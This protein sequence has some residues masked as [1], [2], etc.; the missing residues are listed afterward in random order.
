[1]NRHAH[2]P[3]RLTGVAAVLAALLLG[4]GGSPGENTVTL[5][6][7][8][9]DHGDGAANSS[10]PRFDEM[11]TLPPVIR[12]APAAMTGSGKHQDVKRF[13]AVLPNASF[14]P[15]GDPAW[16]RVGTRITPQIGGAATGDARQVP[17]ELQKAAVQ[18]AGRV[19]EWPAQPGGRRAAGGREAVGAA[20][21]PAISPG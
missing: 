13:L 15:F 9:A 8:A 10:R 16:E 4:G 6:L 3:G 14:H 2:V 5:R 17:V 11:Y 12:G 20:V 18:E 1:M 7:V 19:R 21:G